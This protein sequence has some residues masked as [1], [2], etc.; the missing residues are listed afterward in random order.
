MGIQMKNNTDRPVII[1]VCGKGGVGKTSIS[2]MIT[3]MY[4]E[5]PKNRVL[6]IDADP[7]VGLSFPLGIQV[8]KTVDDIRNTLILRIKNGE[9]TEKQTLL[10]QLDYELFDAME[11][12]D[13]LSFLAI[14]RPEGDGCYCQVNHLLKDIIKEVSG[15]FDFVIIDGEAGVEQI[16][17]RVMEMVTHLLL[18][19]DASLKGRHVASTIAGVA[20]R[21]CT[22]EKVG[23]LLNRIHH[24][25]NV[26]SFLPSIELPVIGVVPEDN[27][28]RTF[29]REGRKF[30]D[31]PRCDPVIVLENAM[32]SFG[33]RTIEHQISVDDCSS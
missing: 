15:N 29:D 32:S 16:S 18:V 21:S 6:A 25:D 2:A 3:K 26:K 23:L 24:S 22:F 33:I 8:K 7:A 1:A 27:I 4:S 11:E 31:M 14:G 12:K 10:R 13:N 9:N 28:I 30:F 17:R 20:N 19:T 5:N